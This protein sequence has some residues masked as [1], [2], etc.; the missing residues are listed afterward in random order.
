M[1]KNRQLD[2]SI[3]IQL[4]CKKDEYNSQDVVNSEKK[5][6][7]TL[8][9]DS[10][11]RRIIEQIEGEI[12]GLISEMQRTIHHSTMLT[13]GEEARKEEGKT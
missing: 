5:L 11:K 2:L 10:P 4:R 13:D 3:S 9:T 6:I 8:H 1:S 12:D 7:L